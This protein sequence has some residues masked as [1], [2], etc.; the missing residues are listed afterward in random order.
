MTTTY[1]RSNYCAQKPPVLRC[2]PRDQIVRDATFREITVFS[3][4]EVHLLPCERP[5]GTLESA[6]RTS[7]RADTV[8]ERW[9][10]YWCD[11]D[12][13]YYA[14]CVGPDGTDQWFRFGEEETRLAVADE[15]VLTLRPKDAKHLHTR[16]ILLRPSQGRRPILVGTSRRDTRTRVRGSAG[17]IL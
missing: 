5:Q 8:R 9:E 17:G 3:S 12:E 1:G 15:R 10:G 2:A 6:P 14:R 16:M 13:G 4:R 11:T 7:L